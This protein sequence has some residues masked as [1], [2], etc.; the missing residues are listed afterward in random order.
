MNR[1]LLL[2]PLA[3]L[4]TVPHAAQTKGRVGF[5]NITQVMANMPGSA[6][7]LSLRKTVNAD[8]TKR[9]AALRT[10][11]AKANT[12][13]KAA[14]ITAVN[15][16]QQDYATAQK[17]YQSRLATSF[18]PLAAKLDGAI[19]TVARSNGYSVVLDKEVAGRT[20]LVVYADIASTDL[21]AAVQ[22]QLKK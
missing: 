12:T 2:L 20:S 7:Y 10:L 5:V 3:L 17:G 1:M 22:K 4:A 18:K 8:L 16:A 15:K 21:T 14:D 13:R 9:Q 11:I 6:N 19:A